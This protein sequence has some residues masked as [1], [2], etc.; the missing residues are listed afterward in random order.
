[1]NFE[2]GK[3]YK[4][5]TYY[6]LIYSRAS[7]PTESPLA[8]AFSCMSSIATEAKYWSNKLNCTVCFSKLNEIFMFLKEETT[9]EERYLN[10][11]FGDKQGWIINRYWLG[12]ERIK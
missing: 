10:V 12:V 7:P 5:P 2:K 4:C 6:L 11:L 8:A 3:L 1:M 9:E